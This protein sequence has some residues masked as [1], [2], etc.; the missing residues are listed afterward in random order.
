MD[1]SLTQVITCTTTR[2]FVHQ[3]NQ[4]AHR[5]PAELR[6][7]FRFAIGKIL[8]EDF[9]HAYRTVHGKTVADLLAGACVETEEHWANESLTD[10]LSWE[11]TSF[12]IHPGSLPVLL[13]D[14]VQKLVEGDVEIRKEARDF[15]AQW[16]IESADIV[17]QLGAVP[18]FV[19]LLLH[20]IVA[21]REDVEQD[22][23]LHTSVVLGLPDY[24]LDR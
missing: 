19:R 10:C 2:D 6:S 13:G 17:G 15:L 16:P 1:E 23:E 12:A 21:D 8:L 18:L 11:W 22:I 14:F 24:V 3:A 4:I 7:W 5:L 9:T 20:L